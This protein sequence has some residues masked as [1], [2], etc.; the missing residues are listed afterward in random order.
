VTAIIWSFIHIFKYIIFKEHEIG[1]IGHI[2]MNNVV[3]G[4][5]PRLR[6]EQVDTEVDGGT[7]LWIGKDY[8][9]PIK[10]DFFAID[11]PYEG[12]CAV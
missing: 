7:R 11:K 4:G 1:R 3:D 2:L 10:K 5:D 12:M 8:S 9:N 6:F